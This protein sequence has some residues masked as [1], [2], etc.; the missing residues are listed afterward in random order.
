MLESAKQLKKIDLDYYVIN[1]QWFGVVYIFFCIICRTQI[2]RS[3]LQSHL[4]A[5]LSLVIN[6]KKKERKKKK[7]KIE[8]FLQAFTRNFSW[9]SLS[10]II[11]RTSTD[12]AQTD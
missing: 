2:G 3:C 11:Y 4:M 10:W 6:K 1:H 8:T 9:I 12:H 5:T 7:E